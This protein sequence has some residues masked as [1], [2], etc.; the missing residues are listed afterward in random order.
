MKT[1]IATLTFFLTLNFLFS[2][3][4]AKRFVLLSRQEAEMTSYANDPEANALVL[5]ESGSVQFVDEV[6]GIYTKTDFYKKI[7]IFNSEGYKYATF[8]IPLYKNSRHTESVLNIKA[9]THN[10]TV[11]VELDKAQIF[12]DKVTENWSEVK[13]TLPAIT[14]SSVVEVFYTVKSPFFFNL[15]GWQ[16]Q[17]DIPKLQ[18]KFKALIPGNFTYNRSLIGS[19]K[20]ATNS[21]QIKKR[22][23]NVTGYA[24]PSDCEDL[25]Y[26][27]KDI[28][29]FVE[30]K[31]MTSDKN[32]KSKI[33]FELEKT[34]WFN[35]V[36]QNYTT[37]WDAV[38]KE[39]KYDKNIGRQF[40]KSDVVE[41]LIPSEIREIKDELERAKATFYFIQKYFSWNEKYSIFKNVNIKE[42]VSE[43]VGNVSEINISLT[44]ALIATKLNAEIVMISTRE[45]GFPTR[46]Y[47]VMSDFNYIISKVKINDKTY[48]LDA[49]DKL[50]SFGILPFR[51]LNSYGRAIDFQNPSDWIDIIPENPSKNDLLGILKLQEN[52]IITG[53]IKKLTTLYEA[54]ERREEVTP[55]SNDAIISKFENNF[56]NI[57]VISYKNENLKDIDKPLIEYF[58]IS[59]ENGDI[60]GM[61]YLNPFFENSKMSNPFKQEDRLYPVDFGYTQSNTILF[62]LELPPNFKVVSAPESQSLSLEQNAGNFTVKSAI[63][64]FKVTVKSTFTINKSLFYNNE[65][66]SLKELYKQ[67]IA[68]YNTPL[69]LKKDAVK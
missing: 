14:D 3:E 49:T 48:F 38:D 32:F 59:V 25:V 51:C 60:N 28:P 22:C 46:L 27:M 24:Q 47:P 61:H 10:G 66:A 9:L 40:K 68:I 11:R 35:G 2:Q 13:F 67:T 53:K 43:K 5:F 45:N 17:S 20:L 52:G 1:K 8:K 26:E 64:S 15:T 37:T 39:L 19:L 57:K 18:S 21:S 7:K 16:F 42:A 6:D 31:Y 55:L 69:V 34:T 54:K 56:K 50:V 12:D 44:N 65:Y 30:E 36:I 63:E 41:S 62:S 29:A 58:E 23:F 33:K 4:D